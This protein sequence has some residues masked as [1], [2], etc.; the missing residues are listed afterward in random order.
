VRVVLSSGTVVPFVDTVAARSTWILTTSQQI[1]IPLGQSWSA[2]VTSRG[3]TG[4]VVERLE[5]GASSAPAPQWGL[6]A[7]LPSAAVGLDNGWIV[8]APVASGEQAPS[9]LGAFSVVLADPGS[10]AL[11]VRLYAVEASGLHLLDNGHDTTTML[12][13][14]STTDVPVQSPYPVEV[15]SNGPVAV[16]GDT[17]NPEAPNVLAIPAFPLS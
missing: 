6:V 3:G 16:I 14:G 12:K 15:V 8:P 4:V 7:A 17:S 5:Q 2:E 11:R 1:H 9:S 10:T 13:P